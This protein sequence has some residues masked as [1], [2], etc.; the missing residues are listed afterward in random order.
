MDNPVGNQAKSSSTERILAL[1]AAAICLILTLLVWQRIGRQQPMWPFPALYL[2]QLL[3]LTVAAAAATFRH[4][5]ATGILIWVAFG[6]ISAFSVLAGFS[7]GSLYVPV[8]VLL[9]IMGLQFIRR[10][11]RHPWMFLG[12]VAVAALAALAQVGILLAAIRILNPNW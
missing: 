9:L 4:V 2:I 12:L 5:A 8:A 11:G 3:A 1:L 10:T 7:V 6:A